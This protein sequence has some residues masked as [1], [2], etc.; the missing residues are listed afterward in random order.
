MK[1]LISVL[2]A[3]LLLLAALV[4]CTG[5][6]ETPTD[7][8]EHTAERNASG[9]TLAFL[10]NGCEV[11]VLKPDGNGTKKTASVTVRNNTDRSFEYISFYVRT[12]RRRLLFS[13][14]ALPA[15][16]S[17]RIT[18]K[19]GAAYI[20]GETARTID[21]ENSAEFADAV[22]LN[23]DIFEISA[24]GSVMNVKNISKRDIPEPICVYYK[25]VYADGAFG[26]E[27]YR[28]FV[29]GGLAAGE[30]KQIPSA[31]FK[32]GESKVVFVTYA[33]ENL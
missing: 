7:A 22:S 6:S 3:V 27:T 30:L 15:G 26:E 13:L 24:L 17:A 12:D 8:A 14:T 16:E 18:E 4:S 29:P 33:D 28:S 9:D 5:G 20:E 10:N 25:T 31:H 1:K 19:N 11:T 23:E 32:K 21:G 2:S